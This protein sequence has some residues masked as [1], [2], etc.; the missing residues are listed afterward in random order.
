MGFPLLLKPFYFK[1][2]LIKLL[3]VCINT[4]VNLKINQYSTG[5]FVSY[6]RKKPKLE[7]NP[8]FQMAMPA[9]K[10]SIRTVRFGLMKLGPPKVPALRGG[11]Y[12]TN[13]AHKENKSIIKFFFFFRILWHFVESTKMFKDDIISTYSL[14]A[15]GYETFEEAPWH[16]A[17]RHS[18]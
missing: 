18:I 16:S 11:H 6:S 17:Q 15:T 10:L 2:L 1:H 9:R 4:F 13:S 3:D 14:K 12:S 8:F 7:T 5:L